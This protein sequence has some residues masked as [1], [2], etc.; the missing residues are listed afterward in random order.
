MLF[1]PNEIHPYTFAPTIVG[2]GVVITAKDGG[3]QMIVSRDDITRA[4]NNPELDPHRRAMYEEAKRVLR[5]ASR[6]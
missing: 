3:K 6:S 1:A 4:L 5:K 2:E